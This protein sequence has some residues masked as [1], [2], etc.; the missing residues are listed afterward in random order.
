MISRIVPC[1]ALMLAAPA[2]AQT[3]FV[4][5]EFYDPHRAMDGQS[6]ISFC[7]FEDISTA[8]VDVRIAEEIGATL[9]VEPLIHRVELRPGSRTDDDFWQLVFLLLNEKCAAVM[10][11]EIA[12]GTMVPNWLTITQPYFEAPFVLATREESIQSLADLG[13]GMLVGIPVNSRADIVMQDYERTLPPDAGWM[14]IPYQLPE[15]QIR[16]LAEGVLAAAVVWE[17]TARWHIA[18]SHADAGIDL[19][20]LRPL[21][22]VTRSLAM[23]LRSDDVALRTQLDIAL[24][25]IRAAGGL[26]G[27]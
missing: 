26:S 23:L 22:P 10:G 5:P 8:D 4:P 14:R 1:L 6:A 7:V 18:R 25:E 9:L 15:D 17:P 3:P 27:R 16:H 21:P 11:T 19:R 2:A 20:P 13:A 24:S 12:P